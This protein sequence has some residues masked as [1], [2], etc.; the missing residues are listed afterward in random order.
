MAV[1]KLK[2]GQKIFISLL[3][4]NEQ[5]LSSV[6]DMDDRV[7]YIPVPFAQNR[8]LVLSRGDKVNVKYMGEQCAYT[9]VA[10]AIGRKVEDQKL[11]MYILTQPGESDITRVQLRQFVRV[12]VSLD[13]NY[14][15][16]PANNE[17]PTFEKGFTVDL[18]AGG[19]KLATKQSIR[20]GTTILVCFT[21]KARKQKQPEELKLLGKVI[22]SELVDP[23]LNTYHSGIQFIDITRQQQDLIMAFLFERMAQIKRKR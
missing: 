23:E 12:P 14:A 20:P 22:R 1:E 13:V 2:V 8:P 7:I 21:I 6:H 4:E 5:Y 16:P 15:L 18:S 11:P 9:F 17:P 19:M 3:N 10:K